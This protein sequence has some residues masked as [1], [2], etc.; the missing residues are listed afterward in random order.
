MDL[1]GVKWPLPP[2]DL[3]TSRSLFDEVWSWELM[4]TMWGISWLFKRCINYRW[5]MKNKYHSGYITTFTNFLI[6]SCHFID[7][8][9][10]KGPLVRVES[11]HKNIWKRPPINLM[12]T[13]QE[14]SKALEFQWAWFWIVKTTLVKYSKYKSPINHVSHTEDSW[15]LTCSFLKSNATERNSYKWTFETVQ[16]I[17]CINSVSL[18]LFPFKWKVIYFRVDPLEVRNDFTFLLK[19]PKCLVLD[20]STFNFQHIQSK[21]NVI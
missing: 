17:H 19:A 14:Y 9:P 15:S 21:D 16:S 4:V 7:W 8:F 1:P 6:F 5:W 13:R 11:F 10:S 20:T 2:L 3:W 18:A 12:L